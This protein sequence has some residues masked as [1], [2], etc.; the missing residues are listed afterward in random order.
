MLKK[1]TL[2]LSPLPNQGIAGKIELEINTTN[3]DTAKV[4]AA[5]MVGHMNSA[6]VK[7]RWGKDVPSTQWQIHSLEP[8]KDQ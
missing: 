3:D 1:Y 5:F 4:R 7:D 2:V 8:S 6:T